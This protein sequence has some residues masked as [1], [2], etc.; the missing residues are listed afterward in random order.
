M[1]RACP[2][3]ET[4]F[5][6]SCP[7]LPISV[8]VRSGRVPLLRFDAGWPFL[9]AGLAILVCC[10]V[11]PAQVDL[12]ELQAQLDRLERQEGNSFKRL[13][14]YG[15][16]LDDLDEG[17]PQLVRRLLASQL[18]LMPA[19]EQ[20]LLVA[21]SLQSGFDSWIEATLQLDQLDDQVTY[22]D[23]LLVRLTDGPR[24]LW[25]VGGGALC[26]FIGLLLGPITANRMNLEHS[27]DSARLKEQ[28][29]HSSRI[30]VQEAVL[31]E[32]DSISIPE[33]EGGFDE[34]EEL[35]EEEDEELVGEDEELEEE[36]DEEL[37]GEDEELE[38]EEDEELVGEDEELEEEEDE[39]LVEGEYVVEY[40]DEDGN[41]IDPEHLDPDEYEIVEE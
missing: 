39:E 6:F 5:P 33:F 3:I 17:E 10:A 41:P 30:L 22:P 19:Q 7:H 36:E 31:A 12:H 14:A 32:Q 13:E 1:L 18:N 28:A 16:F 11:I 29:A 25:A 35:E 9:L 20:P 21:T 37:V 24:R 2:R 34:D 40:V 23:T 27:A 8:V 4:S 15:R 38:E 26:I